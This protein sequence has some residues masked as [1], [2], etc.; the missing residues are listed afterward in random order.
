MIRPDR[1]A[2]NRKEMETEISRLIQS[3][4]ESGLM[5]VEIAQRILDYVGV[6]WRDVHA[7]EP[8][9]LNVDSSDD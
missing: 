2:P 3:G 5:P 1:P 4:E 6:F 9:K 8:N 7:A